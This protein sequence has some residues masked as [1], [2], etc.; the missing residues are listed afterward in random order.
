MKVLSAILATAVLV[1]TI[2]FAATAASAHWGH[3]VCHSAHHHHHW[4]RH[5]H[6]AR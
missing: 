4:W 6:W 3:R 1:G 5:C 2:D